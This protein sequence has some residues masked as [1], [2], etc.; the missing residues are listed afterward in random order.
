[1]SCFIRFRFIFRVTADWEDSSTVSNLLRKEHWLVIQLVK[2]KNIENQ[3]WQQC[4]QIVFKSFL[5]VQWNLGALCAWI[6]SIRYNSW[7]KLIKRLQIYSCVVKL[8]KLHFS[9]W[10]NGVTFEK[11]KNFIFRKKIW[12]LKLF[13]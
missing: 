5:K 1:M 4:V 9:I 11:V 10:I 2:F 13:K 3:T 6:T 7:T 8:N 12:S